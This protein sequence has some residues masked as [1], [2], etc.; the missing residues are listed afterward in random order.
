MP[1]EGYKPN[2]YGVSIGPDG[3]KVE[4]E[5]RQCIHCQGMW[6]YRPGSGIQRGYCLR[7]N[8]LLCCRPECQTQQLKWIAWWL[9]KT[10]KVRQCIPFHEW[11]SRLGEK[12]L[13]K[14]DNYTITESGILVPRES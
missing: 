4:T 7:C 8:G 5:T 9:E 6:T 11:N 14:A 2:G 12:V 13:H 10:S 1:I 3:N